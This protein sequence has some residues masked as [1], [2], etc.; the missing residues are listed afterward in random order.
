MAV[1]VVVA[2]GSQTDEEGPPGNRLE[3]PP[4]IVKGLAASFVVET[5]SRGMELDSEKVGGRRLTAGARV[6]RAAGRTVRVGEAD[7]SLGQS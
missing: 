2:V 4:G 6:R 5:S 1:V 3:A 7:R